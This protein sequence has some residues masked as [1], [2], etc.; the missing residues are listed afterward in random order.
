MASTMN[1]LERK[2]RASFIKGFFIALLIGILIIAFLALQ[3]FNKIEEN[4]FS[5]DCFSFEEKCNI[6]RNID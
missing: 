6:W 1:P 3:L 5:K 2:A 4:I